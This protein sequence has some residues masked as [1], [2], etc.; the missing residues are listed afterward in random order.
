MSSKHS[1]QINTSSKVI[2]TGSGRAGT[3]FLIRLLT[4][5]GFDTGFEPYKEKGYREELRAGCERKIH[6]DILQHKLTPEAKKHWDNFPEIIKGPTLSFVLRTYV[7]SGYVKIR[8]LFLPIRDL[9]EAADSRDSVG[10]QQGF[11]GDEHI[12]S[13][14]WSSA[15][16]GNAIAAAVLFEIPTT[17]MR[18]PDVVTNSDY[19]YHKL[20]EGLKMPGKRKFNKVFKELCQEHA[21]EN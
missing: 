3:T 17:V 7:R 16:L 10:L 5:L 9:Y 14:L 19:C 1:K 8:H 2:I 15:A 11:E 6:D 21:K 20:S 18:F 13:W 12:N 4:R